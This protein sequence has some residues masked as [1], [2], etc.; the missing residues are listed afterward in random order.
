LSE[1]VIQIV[2]SSIAKVKK[3]D[4]DAV[5]LD[6]TVEEY[7]FKLDPDQVISLPLSAK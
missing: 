1:K 4:S 6:S 7:F 5:K 2:V 3:M